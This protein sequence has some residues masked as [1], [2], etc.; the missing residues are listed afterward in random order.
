MSLIRS[1]SS[2]LAI[3]F[4]LAGCT[5]S[6]EA[7]T[8]KDTGTSAP[9]SS[10]VIEKVAACLNADGWDVEVDPA[11]GGLAFSGSAEQYKAYQKALDACYA[12]H[13]T[14]P[15]DLDDLSEEEWR[16]L[17]AQETKASECLREAG[18]A[19]PALP[20]YQVF[21]ERY[22]GS[23][24]WTSYSFVQVAGDEWHELNERCPQPHL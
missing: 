3:A 19:I 15:R 18:V 24:P 13:D 20:S 11:D 17:Y 7:N 22:K 10:Q 21:V 23:E 16:T 12:E 14:K 2:I 6:N 4:A 9:S 5:S 1:V 8:A